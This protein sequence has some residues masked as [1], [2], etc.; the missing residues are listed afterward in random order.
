MNRTLTQSAAV[1]IV[2]AGMSA[3]NAFA[4]LTLDQSPITQKTCDSRFDLTP[5]Q[6]IERAVPVDSKRFTEPG[7]KEL[8]TDDWSN[9]LLALLH[10][11]N[12]TDFDEGNLTIVDCVGSSQ[13]IHV[14]SRDFDLNYLDRQGNEERGWRFSAHAN[15]EEEGVLRILR[16]E[17]PANHEWKINAAGDG[18]I[19]TQALFH[20]LNFRIN[21]VLSTDGPIAT[22]GTNTVGINS[23]APD[24]VFPDQIRQDGVR[25]ER[26]RVTE[27]KHIGD[28]LQF[29]QLTTTNRTFDERRIWTIN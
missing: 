28:S 25:Y 19:A 12:E 20:Q 29:E 13:T 18:L 26:V 21:E 11:L 27:V 6:L 3:G 2:A 24:S 10:E 14:R 7:E 23:S 4:N 17:L 1:I 22:F 9:G 16:L 15:R 8:N 5:D